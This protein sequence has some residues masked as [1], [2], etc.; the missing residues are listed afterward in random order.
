[1]L[2]INLSLFEQEVENKANIILL[3][4]SYNKEVSF[5]FFFFEIFL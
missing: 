5:F 1:M 3:P 2:N 4:L